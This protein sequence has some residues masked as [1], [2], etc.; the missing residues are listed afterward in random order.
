[1]TRIGPQMERALTYIRQH[2][3]CCLLDVCQHITRSRSASPTGHGQDQ[4]VQR[5]MR[6]GLVRGA[7]HHGRWYL[8][9]GEEG[10]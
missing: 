10:L 2:P 9:V 4:V 8:Y 1:M 5:L 3:G 6:R 7:K